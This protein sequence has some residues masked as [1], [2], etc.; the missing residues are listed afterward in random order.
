MRKSVIH[1][2]T[3]MTPLRVSLVGGGTDFPAFYKLQNGL[4]VS[5]TIQKFIYVTVKRHS[6]LFGE[7]YRISYSET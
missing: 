6:P 5:M 2:V 4:V 3:T 7:K 1:S